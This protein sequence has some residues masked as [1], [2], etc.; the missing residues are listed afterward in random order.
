MV[1]PT[2][3]FFLGGPWNEELRVLNMGE[4]DSAYIYV[5]TLDTP[6]IY[7]EDVN[8]PVE[9]KKHRYNIRKTMCDGLYGPRAIATCEGFDEQYLIDLAF[10][11]LLQKGQ[12]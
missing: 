6:I 4:C 2:E 9:V 3:V 12:Q 8:S 10:D 1:R 7:T 5:A 11:A